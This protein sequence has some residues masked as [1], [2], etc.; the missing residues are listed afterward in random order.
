[1]IG[2]YKVIYAGSKNRANLWRL[3]GKKIT[4]NLNEYDGDRTDEGDITPNLNEHNEL[5]DEVHMEVHS[6]KSLEGHDK[7]NFN[8]LNE[9]IGG[10]G[11]NNP[12]DSLNISDTIQYNCDISNE[13]KNVI[14][15]DVHKV[16]TSSFTITDQHL[17]SY[18]LHEPKFISS[19]DIRCESSSQPDEISSHSTPNQN[20]YEHILNN[21]SKHTLTPFIC[22]SGCKHYDGVT[23]VNDGMFKEFC[24]YR[25]SYR[26]E[27]SHPCSHFE[28][29][30]SVG[31]DEDGILMF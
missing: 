10:V 1:V 23:D 12:D 29:K 5:R 11:K 3:V 13:N 30:N 31:D 17:S 16:H 9:L 21:I 4:L 25:R 27:E 15:N 19:L 22:R 6:S 28:N 14:L 20:P 2:E 8:E 26:L 7:M 18:E 24:C